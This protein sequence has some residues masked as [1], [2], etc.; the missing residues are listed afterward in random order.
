MVQGVG[1]STYCVLVRPTKHIDYPL[2][3]FASAKLH[4]LVGGFRD[5]GDFDLAASTIKNM[6]KVRNTSKR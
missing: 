2:A 3:F 4:V 1:S 6:I 5:T